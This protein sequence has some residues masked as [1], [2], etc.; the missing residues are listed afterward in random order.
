VSYE[1][2]FSITPKL[3]SQVEIVAA[4]R[5]RILS[6]AVELSRMPALQKDTFLEHQGRW[7]YTE[8][9]SGDSADGMHTPDTIKPDIR[10]A[11]TS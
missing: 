3:L 4:L 1:P 7:A 2:Q 5:E 10:L 11:F 9:H 8:M 6:A